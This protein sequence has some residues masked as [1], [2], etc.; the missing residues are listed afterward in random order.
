MDA[1][2]PES[3]GSMIRTLA[4]LVMASW[5]SES[6]VESLPCAFTTE[7]CEGVSPAVAR[8]WD[9]YG[10]SNSVYRAEDTVSGRMTATLPLPAAARGFSEAIALKVRSSWP[11]EIDG[12]VPAELEEVEPE[13]LDELPELLQAA[14]ARHKARDTRTPTPFFG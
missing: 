9:R 8:A 11:T 2:T 4:P 13:L 7:Y 14:A 1:P 10:A 6:S 12:T 3:S 5:A